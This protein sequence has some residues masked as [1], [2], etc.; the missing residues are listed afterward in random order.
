MTAGSP[1]P[2]MNI[3]LVTERML[4]GFGVDLCVDQLAAGLVRRGHRVTVY[5]S[6]ADH[7]YQDRPY[8]L[9]ITPVRATKLFPLMDRRGRS[10]ARLFDH[11]GLDVLEIHSFPFFSAIPRLTTPVVAVDHGVSSTAGMPLWLRTDFAYVR[12]T[13][14]HRYLP[15]ATRLVTISEFLRHRMPGR[16]AERAAVV[17]WG[18]EHY[19]RPVE[20]DQALAYRRSRGI[21][22]DQVLALY[23]GRLNHKGQPYK[24]VAELLQHHRALRE[25]GL[26]VGLLCIGYGSQ[27][28]IRAVAAAGGIAV[29]SAPAAE[30]ALAYCAAD[31]FVTCSRWEGFGLPLLEAQRFGRPAVAY[32]AGAHPEI[33]VAGETA[34]LVGSPEQFREAWRSLV[35]D[36]ERRR[37]MGAAAARHAASYTWERA[38]EAH[39]R[40]LA[41]AAATR[42]RSRPAGTRPPQEGIPPLV[43]VVVLTYEPEPEHLAACLDSIRSSDYPRVEL[44]VL[45]NGSSNGVAERLVA[46]RSGIRFIQIGYNSGFSAG[47]NRGVREATGDFVFLLNPDARVEPRTIGLLVD[48]ARRHPTAIGFAP[49]MVF[50]HDPELID[51]IGTAID[52]LGAAFNRGI[53]QVDVGQYDLEE[54]VMGC[55][56]GAAFLRR[57]AFDPSRVG[58]LDEAYFMYYEDVDWCLRATLQG[59]DFWS[60][61]RARVHHVHSATTRSQAYGFKYRLIQRNLF[62]TVFKNFEKRRTIK[63]FALRS[64]WHL[65]NVLRGPYRRESLR[66][67][68][69]GWTGVVRYWGTRTLQQKRRTRADIDAFKLGYGELSFFDPVAYRPT[70][71]WDT[72]TAMLKRLYAVTGEARWGRAVDYLDVA[73]GTPL[74]FRPREVRQRLVEIAGPLPEPLQRFFTMLE[75][76]PGMLVPADGAVAGRA[77]AAPAA[78]R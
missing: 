23:V 73:L 20:P 70:Y 60:V 10:W 47:I 26:P 65:V 29:L 14:Y 41:E 11:E 30:M 69:E 58:P 25:E 51:A 43:S 62:H 18:S 74:R 76:Q 68:W 21:T 45:D 28:D 54:P 2:G 7:T 15:R 59:E 61:P 55:C 12:W 13:L 1:G 3:G 78:I 17:P 66:V 8:R 33:A 48:A 75:R 9:R 71:T 16:L 6:V 35:T 57:E 40:I 27:E 39:E 4:T 56:F 31:L 19:W 64:R 24:G 5:C 52:P 50:A 46:E 53:G 32:A 36:P 44:L 49:K 22:D 72:L 77:E 67:L 38:V 42:P 63:V 34:L 37:A